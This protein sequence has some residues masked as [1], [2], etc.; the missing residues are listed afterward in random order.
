MVIRRTVPNSS[1]E[2][3][4]QLVQKIAAQVAQEQGETAPIIN[5]DSCNINLPE[6]LLKPNG[7]L[8]RVMDYMER[9]NVVSYP[10]YNLAGAISLLG[11]IAGQQVCT[12]TDLRTNVYCLIIGRS[13]SGKESPVRSIDYLTSTELLQRFHGIKN[14]AS[15][16]AIL[17]LLNDSNVR[18]LALDEMGQLLSAA[19]GKNTAHHDLI[20]LFMELYTKTA[21][22]YDKYYADSSRNF[23]IYGPHLS[24][25]GSSTPNEIFE[26]LGSKNITSGFLPR[27]LIFPSEHPPQSK[28]YSVDIDT[29]CKELQ[30]ELE[31]IAII[32]DPNQTR[33]TEEVRPVTISPDRLANAL[34]A[35]FGELAFQKENASYRDEIANPIYSRLF[36][37]GTKLSLIHAVSRCGA[38][39]VNQ[40]IKPEDCNWGYQLAEKMLNWMVEKSPENF[41]GSGKFSKDKRKLL[42]VM[43]KFH[44]QGEARVSR[45]DL[46]RF[47][48]MNKRELSP[49]LETLV[50]TQEIEEFTQKA[51]NGKTMYSYKFKNQ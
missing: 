21:G 32:N 34:I 38:D 12:N 2:N 9:S 51:P 29:D 16:P 15:G 3:N 46:L 6:H 20:R 31:M 33:T 19:Q 39:I 41:T 4:E 40:K 47:T 42:S 44:G 8:G 30:R 50:E 45:S 5:D 25:L 13:G 10:L 18:L 14:I 22:T 11:T 26:A 1:E 35:K 17:N 23:T 49:I 27:C 36:E 7:L 43:K 28:K 24:I 48:N 37:Q